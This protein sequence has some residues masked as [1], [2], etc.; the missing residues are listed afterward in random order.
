[1]AAATM[2][3]SAPFPLWP[4]QPVSPDDVAP[5][6]TPYLLGGPEP[7]GAVI[8]CPGGG[9]ARRAPHEGAPVAAWLNSL[10]IAAFVLDY[11]VAPHRHPLPLGDAQRAI[12]TVRQRA[13]DWAI[14]PDRIGILGFSAGGHVAASAGTHYD[15]GNPQAV[16]PIERLSCRPDALAL[17]YA[18]LTFGEFRHEGSMVNLL[19]PEPPEDLRRLL[20]NEL[21]VSRDTPPTFLWHTGDDAGVPVENSLL[22]AGALRRH[23]VPFALHIFPHGRHG[24]GLA[25]DDPVVGAWPA[26]CGRWLLAGDFGT[27]ERA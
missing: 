13:Q 12:R 19:G 24:L 21:Q 26:L 8:V 14:R 4:D 6:L 22:F 25:S 9:Y 2:D 11:R 15:S 17:C 16:D 18:V 5:R 10:G 20:S 3:T 7:T 23:G 27:A 1:M